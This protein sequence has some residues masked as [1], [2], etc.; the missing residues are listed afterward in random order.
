MIDGV[1][2]ETDRV[3]IFAYGKLKRKAH[4]MVFGP[5]GSRAS[6]PQ[7]AEGAQTIADSEQPCNFLKVRSTMFAL[8]AHCGRDARDP[9]TA[10]CLLPTAFCLLPSAF[11]TDCQLKC[12]HSG[13]R[14]K[15]Q[16]YSAF[17]RRLPL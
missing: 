16:K 17:V 4:Q 14:R 15:T 13:V 1:Q 3:K 10:H 6:R 11:Y 5:T 12:L 9:I 7:C 2:A 8:R